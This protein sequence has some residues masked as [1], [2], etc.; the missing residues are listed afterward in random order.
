L[1]IVLPVLALVKLPVLLVNCSRWLGKEEKYKSSHGKFAA[2]SIS[3]IG[4]DI[5]VSPLKLVDPVQFYSNMCAP[6]DQPPLGERHAPVGQEDDSEGNLPHKHKMIHNSIVI[7]KTLNPCSNHPSM[8]VVHCPVPPYGT[9]TLHE[10]SQTSQAGMTK[11]DSPPDIE[12]HTISTP[13]HPRLKT[14]SFDLSKVIKPVFFNT[15]MEEEVPT[16]NLNLKPE[17]IRSTRLSSF[18]SPHNSKAPPP[19]P[20]PKPQLVTNARHPP[21]PF[22]RSATTLPRPVR[23]ISTVSNSTIPGQMSY[24]PTPTVQLVLDPHDSDTSGSVQSVTPIIR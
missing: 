20:L 1:R 23:L 22:S 3:W 9:L 19:P 13:K 10:E 4:L 6:V 16:S 5:L 18:S 21:P 14:P 11:N 12:E 24:P 8:T 2:D 15:S 17:A 7:A